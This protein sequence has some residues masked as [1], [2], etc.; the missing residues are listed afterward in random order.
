MCFILCNWLLKC[1]IITY[2]QVHTL[3]IC[4]YP[5]IKIPLGVH[6]SYLKQVETLA[7]HVYGTCS[8]CSAKSLWLLL[9]ESH[10]EHCSCCLL[11]PWHHTDNL[12][13]RLLH[14]YNINSLISTGWQLMRWYYPGIC[15]RVHLQHGRWNYHLLHSLNA[16]L[17][18]ELIS[19]EVMSPLFSVVSPSLSQALSELSHYHGCTHVQFGRHQ[20]KSTSVI[21]WT[22]TEQGPVRLFFFL[23]FSYFIHFSSKIKSS[24]KFTVYFLINLIIQS[25][26]AT[27]KIVKIIFCQGW[28]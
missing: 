18:L 15:R 2:L 20:C 21:T 11:L 22:R 26:T 10:P 17:R 25:L 19:P 3:Y 9:L 4:K 14:P 8:Q 7:F 28:P 27:T 12:L 24:F 1:N 5:Y 23:F 13:F 6:S 16:W